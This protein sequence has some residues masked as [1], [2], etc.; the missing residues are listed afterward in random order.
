[1]VVGPADPCSRVRAVAERQPRNGG[2]GPR[3]VDGLVLVDGVDGEIVAAFTE[4]NPEDWTD[5]DGELGQA[6]AS[7]SESGDE[8]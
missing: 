5:L 4:N 6:I 1:M 2:V 7:P 3:G 8:E